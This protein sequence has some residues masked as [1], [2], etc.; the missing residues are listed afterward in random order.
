M[1]IITLNK[2]LLKKKQFSYECR[3]Q[4]RVRPTL[5]GHV[6]QGDQAQIM[7]PLVRVQ[8]SKKIMDMWTENDDQ[9]AVQGD[10]EK[11]AK[12]EMVQNIKW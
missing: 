7:R 4:L 9:V 12:M 2:F 3:K 8:E 6:K 5:F 11:E 1:N 10:K